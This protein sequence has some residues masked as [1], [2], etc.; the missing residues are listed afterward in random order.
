MRQMQGGGGGRGGRGGGF[1]GGGGGKQ[2]GGD[3]TSIQNIA[4]LFSTI[5]DTQVGEIPATN[6]IVGLDGG[7]TGTGLGGGG[8][9]GGRPGRGGGL[10][11]QEDGAGLGGNSS[12]EGESPI[13][14]LLQRLIPDVY[15]PSSEER[16]S[17]MIY[18]PANNMLIVTNTPTNLDSFEEQLTQLDVTPKQVSIEA[19][20]L[21]IRVSDMDKVGFQWDLNAESNHGARLPTGL[22]NSTYEYDIN[23]DNV[24]E[25][26]QL[27]ER[28]DGSNA[29]SNT[30][31][32]TVAEAMTSPGPAA[33]TFN[34][35]TSIID[36]GSGDSLSVT[37][38]YLNGLEESELLSAPRVTT[39]NRKPAVIVDYT[40]EYFQVYSQSGVVPGS[41]SVNGTTQP[42]LINDSLA[43]PFNFGIGLSVTPQIRDNDQVRLWLNPEVRTR[44]GEKTFRNISVSGDQEIV[45]ETN[46]PTTSWQAVWTNVIVHDG[47]TLVLGGLVQDQS[48]KSEEKLPYVADIPILGFFFRGKSTEVTQSSLLIFVT[49]DIIDSTGARF[50]DLASAE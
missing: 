50:F 31:R 9:G 26:I 23:G 7:G 3:V 28:P 2:G 49:P 13:L 24:L 39:M 48:I 25:E 4:A 16:L 35:M 45:N 40:T 8:G 37:F 17:D 32:E 43:L 19:K 18:N 11:A 6:F 12:L 14:S 36:N 10:N 29:F 20:F 33:S 34:L 5:N 1:G 42:V 44:I 46:Y 27:S 21:T 22:E 15:A 38:D 47:D 30:I 41:N